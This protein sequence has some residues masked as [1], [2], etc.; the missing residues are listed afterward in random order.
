MIGSFFHSH[1]SDGVVA[2]QGQVV[3]NPEPGYWLV[4]LLNWTTGD[5]TI[6]QLVTIEEMKGW[7]F[8]SDKDSMD[9]VYER[10]KDKKVLA[11]IMSPEKLSV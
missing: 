4:Q 5:E 2:W 8:Y 3:D 1:D 6:A 9:W 7:H 10:A 11:S